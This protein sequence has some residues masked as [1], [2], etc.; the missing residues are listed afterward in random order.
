MLQTFINSIYPLPASDLQRGLAAFRSLNL[1][2]GD[3]FVREGETCTQAAFIESGILRTFYPTE[4]GEAR[5]YCFCSE[6]H[7]TTSFKSF[8][9]QAP[10]ALSI[11]ALEPCRLLV[12]SYRD[13]QDLYASSPGWQAIG[14]LLVERE[15]LNMENYANSLNAE[16]AREKY[17]RLLKEQPSV[18]KK[19]PVQHIASYL[20]I[21]RETLSRIRKELSK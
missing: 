4:K 6:H 11:Q 8:I 7:F 13:L 17:L 2:K 1:A 12:I 21:T 16:T 5:T 18:I 10:S 20:G 9:S 14:R 19:A 3:F 15:F